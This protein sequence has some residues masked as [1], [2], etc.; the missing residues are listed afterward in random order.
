MKKL[1]RKTL[2]IL[3]L[4]TL[5]I[6]MASCTNRPE[7]R[8]KKERGS[9]EVY[10]L[11]QTK[12]ALYPVEANIKGQTPRVK[13]EKAIDMLS[14]AQ[15]DSDYV[16]SIP[17][18]IMV[19]S[20]WIKNKNLTI[21]FTRAYRNMN[22][23]NEALM[24]ASLVKTLVQI[25]GIDTVTFRVV[26]DQITD[27]QGNPIGAMNAE[28]FVDD[29]G[30]EQD[31]TKALELVLYCPAADGSGLIREKRD[32]HVN[33]NV[34]LATA[35]IRQLQ[36]NPDSNGAL[37]TL[38][39][40]VKVLSVNVNDGICYVDLDQSIDNLDSRVSTNMRIYSIVDSLCELGQISRVQILVGSG[41]QAS[42]ITDDEKNGTYSPNLDFVVND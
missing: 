31:S 14:T 22:R 30:S 5:I 36:K 29:F 17:S 1:I 39:S 4:F 16:N 37:V 18:S 23:V 6:S 9:I 32:V 24:R 27:S 7:G 19:R 8:E 25:D 26:N 2:V 20:F 41:D 33:E 15:E 28:S 40:S 21:S 34:P 12:S 35:V 38:P 10:F 11:N 3:L 13:A 42:V